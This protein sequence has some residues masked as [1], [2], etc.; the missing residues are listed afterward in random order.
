MT[1]SKQHDGE[2]HSQ[3][4]LTITENYGDTG[5]GGPGDISCIQF[6]ELN[7]LHDGEEISYEGASFVQGEGEDSPGGEQAPK[8]FD[9]NPGTKYLT[10][11][12]ENVKVLTIT[13]ATPAVVD[14]LSFSTG[15][16]SP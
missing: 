3:Y 6:G 4:R 13:L 9:N 1:Y 14:D 12:G 15:N 11:R 2:E 8:A 16:D 7:L 10:R 5:C